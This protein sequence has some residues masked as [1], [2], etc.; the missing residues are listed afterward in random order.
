M[1][2]RA[3]LLLTLPLAWSHV[4]AEPPQ[5]L[6]EVMC[7]L[8][9]FE[10]AEEFSQSIHYLRGQMLCND[11]HGGL[12]FEVDTD[13]AKA[14]DTGFIGRPGRADIAPVCA[15]CHTGPGEFFSQGPHHDVAMADN[16]TCVSCHHN[17]LVQ[18]ATLALMDEACTACHAVGTPALARGAAIRSRLQAGHQALQAVAARLDSALAHDRSLK[19]ALPHLDDARTTLRAASPQTHAMNETLIDESLAEFNRDLTAAEKAIAESFEAK[20][21]RRWAVV[22]VWAFVGLNMLLL[23]LKRRQL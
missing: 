17:H 9:H 3:A 18:D 12:P 22:G 19:F 11:C 21:Q 10:Q 15:N 8:C 14:P 6:D 7:A 23:W 1:R 20:R 5:D 2:R 13:L 16:P 4:R